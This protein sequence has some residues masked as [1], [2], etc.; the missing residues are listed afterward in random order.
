MSKIIVNDKE[1]T[2]E[3]FKTLKESLDKNKDMQL[4]EISP[5]KYKTR[6]FG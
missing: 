5:N 6:L 3:E 1:I 4:V 2:E